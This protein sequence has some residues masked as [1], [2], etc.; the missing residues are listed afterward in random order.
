MIVT[1]AGYKGGIGKTTT[2]IHLAAFFQTKAPTLFI[3]ADENRSAQSWARVGQL[4]F[5]VINEKLAPRQVLKLQPTHIVIDTKARPSQEE[6]EDISANCD[7]LI[8]PTS[9]RPMDF[10]VLIKTIQTVRTLGVLYKVLLTMVPP[11]STQISTDLK[12]VLSEDKTPV[13]ESVIHKYAFIEQL[14]LDGLL[15]K[16]SKDRNAKRIWDQY[17]EVGKE[18]LG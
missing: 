3:D 16:D 13:F 17:V 5:E 15:A 8:L 1:V 9:P 11:T 18:I 14:P 4:P 7:L 12:A 2:A 6:L 10:D